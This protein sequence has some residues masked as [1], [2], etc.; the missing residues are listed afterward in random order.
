MSNSVFPTL[1]GLAWSVVKRPNWSN[2]IQRSVS[3]KSFRAARFVYPIWHFT[4]SFDVLRGDGVNHELQTLIGFYNSMN[5]TFDSFLYLDPTDNYTAGQVFAIGDGV[6][7]VFQL[8]RPLGAFVEPVAA[9]Y[10]SPSA[11]VNGSSSG[12]TATFQ[13]NAG[14]V[15]FSSPPANGAV[16]AWTGFYYFRCCFLSD[17]N[18]FENF[19]KDLWTLKKLEFES[20]R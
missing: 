3:G 15:T 18:D 17:H 16:L 7:N 13:A 12:F 9:T 6:T 4:L 8:A 19:M 10:G 2:K 20:I 11:T 1:P 14:T 5:G